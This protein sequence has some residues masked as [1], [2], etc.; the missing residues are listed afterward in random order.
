MQ[1]TSAN[2]KE[3]VLVS[4]LWELLTEHGFRLIKWYSKAREVLVTIR[5]SERAVANLDLEK[6][7]TETAPRLGWNTE[8]DKI[9][10]DALEKILQVV[11]QRPILCM[12]L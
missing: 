12:I 1:S 10:W 11:N 2:E 3:I 4:Q 9:V 8:E 5:E 6:L 7:P